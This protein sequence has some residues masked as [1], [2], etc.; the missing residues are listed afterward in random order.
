LSGYID[1]YDLARTKGL[2]GK[3]D[4][5]WVELAAEHGMPHYHIVETENAKTM[6]VMRHI[7]HEEPPECRWT[8][9]LGVDR[10]GV[11]VFAE[12]ASECIRMSLMFQ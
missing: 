6:S 2:F 9:F 7:V 12:D 8:F 10:A 5:A 4:L 1:L 11:Y 3:S